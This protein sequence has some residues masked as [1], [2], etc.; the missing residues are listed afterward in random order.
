MPKKKDLIWNGVGIGALVFFLISLGLVIWAFSV[1]VEQLTNCPEA[2]AGEPIFCAPP[3]A[4]VILAGGLQEVW[5]SVMLILT[6]IGAVLGGLI[7][8]FIRKK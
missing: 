3:P 6:G 8:F 2:R 5:F 7:D 1:P 4:Y